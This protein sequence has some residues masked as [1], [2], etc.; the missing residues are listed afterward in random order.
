MNASELEAI[1]PLD[2]RTGLDAT[3]VP[4]STD[5]LVGPGV[6][7]AELE[8]PEEQAARPRHICDRDDENGSALSGCWAFDHDD[9]LPLGMGS[10]EDW[11][12]HPQRRI[13]GSS[14]LP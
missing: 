13:S 14:W 11:K 2:R 9:A 6:E 8:F 4:E 10:P 1:E 7:P 3:A 5:E 12:G